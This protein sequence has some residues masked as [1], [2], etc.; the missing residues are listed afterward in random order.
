[1]PEQ[2]R[3]VLLGS[4]LHARALLQVKLTAVY[5]SM[6]LICLIMGTLLVRGALGLVTWVVLGRSL[7]LFPYLLSEVRHGAL[8][9]LRKARVHRKCSHVLPMLLV[10]AYLAFLLLHQLLRRRLQL[11]LYEQYG[12][13]KVP[14]CYREGEWY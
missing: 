11:R 7:W 8:F 12:S 13:S 10:E 2:D 4:H 6:T 3:S 5:C 1:M 9:C 14:G